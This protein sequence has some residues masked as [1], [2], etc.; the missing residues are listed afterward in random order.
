VEDLHFSFKKVKK[1]RIWIEKI[2][3]NEGKS[4]GNISFVFC[5]DKD[6]LKI[7]RQ[8]LKHDFYTDIITFDYSEKGKT[9]GDIFV[10]VERVKENAVAFNQPFQKELM[11]TIIHGILHLCGY[12]DK[13]AADKKRMRMKEDEAL[14]LLD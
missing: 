3:G 8:F 9:E 13:K 2:L 6:L 1:V 12:K 4:H 14:Q 10:S 7:N 11:R 5:T